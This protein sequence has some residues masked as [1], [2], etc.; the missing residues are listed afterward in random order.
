MSAGGSGVE[1][2]ALYKVPLA[3]GSMATISQKFS[4]PNTTAGQGIKFSYV[5]ARVPLEGTWYLLDKAANGSYLLATTVELVLPGTT[6]VLLFCSPS[7]E[8]CV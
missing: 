3:N 6:R 2:S 4:M 7:V 1:Y 5:D 8:G